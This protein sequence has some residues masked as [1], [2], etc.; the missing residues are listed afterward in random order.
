MAYIQFQ[1]HPFDPIDHVDAERTGHR[2]VRMAQCIACHAQ[3]G[4][5][6]VN[7]AFPFAQPHSPRPIS[8]TDVSVDS[9]RQAALRTKQTRYDWG[10]LKGML[11]SQAK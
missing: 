4:I 8:L 3:P 11:D 9:A 2:S 5:F 1:S 7:T 10:L 6:S